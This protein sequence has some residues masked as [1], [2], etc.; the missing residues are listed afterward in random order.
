[1]KTRDYLLTILIVLFSITAQARLVESIYFE[2]D[3]A[4]IQPEEIHKLE[5][6]A[7]AVSAERYEVV[8]L[9]G[10]ADERASEA[11][12]FDLAKRRA[13]AVK[14][15]LQM[16]GIE[17]EIK[18]TLS[19]GEQE[20]VSKELLRN[21]R[22]D[23]HLFAKKVEK[24]RP[25]NFIALHLGVLPHGIE[26]TDRQPFRTRV[27][28]EMNP[29]AGVSYFRRLYKCLHVGATIMTNPT[30]TVNLGCAW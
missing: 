9:V 21:R 13:A 8:I 18:I 30:Y 11:Y 15:Y 2:T 6:V 14:D 16:L 12:N 5:A 3:S 10:N 20:P 25:N 17:D 23:I 29:G 27:Q 7:D 26:A 28:Q 4:M 19:Q 1:M 22:V 24:E